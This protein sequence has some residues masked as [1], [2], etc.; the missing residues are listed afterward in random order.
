MSERTYV[1][2]FRRCPYAIRARMASDA[3]RTWVDAVDEFKPN[4]DRYKYPSR[5]EGVDRESVLE[6][7][8]S[9]L[10]RLNAALEQSPSL[11]DGR[12]TFADIATFPF[13]RQFHFTDP[14]RLNDWGLAALLVWLESFLKSPRFERVMVKRA[15]WEP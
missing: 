13:V 6:Q 15:L 9:C 10:Q 2:T 7:S 1:W 3:I 12:I 5:F 8:L 14:D 4:L 11:L